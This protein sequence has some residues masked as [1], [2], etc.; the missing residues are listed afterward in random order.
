MDVKG[1]YGTF[2]KNT[3]NMIGVE[4]FYAMRN[5]LYNQVTTRFTN[6]DIEVS[7][8][9]VLN[10]FFKFVIFS[11]TYEFVFTESNA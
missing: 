2:R 9:F 5:R 3:I 4:A 10:S 11:I 1:K 8:I 7:S 6:E